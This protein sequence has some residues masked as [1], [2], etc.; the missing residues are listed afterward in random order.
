MKD[1]INIDILLVEDN[2]A[3]IFL[4]KKMLNASALHINSVYTTD[5]VMEAREVL[6]T[7]H[8]HVALLDLSL[9]DSFGIDTYLEI[10]S[11]VKEIPVIILTGLN[12]ANTALEALKEGAQDY[13]IKGEFNGDLLYRAIQYSLE[14]KK[15]E[16]ALLISEEKYKQMFYQGFFPSWIYDPH[17]LQFLEVND[18]AIKKYGY[19]REE[20]LAMTLKDI[21][22]EEDVAELMNIVDKHEAKGTIKLWRHKKKNGNIMTVEVSFFPVNYLG[23]VAS[24]AQMHDVTEEVELQKKLNEQQKAEQKNIT[25]AVLKALESDRA[26]LGAELHDNIN[27]ILATSMLYL[28]HAKNNEVEKDQMIHKSLDVIAL[29]I[30]EIRK[31]SRKLVVS[32]ISEIGLEKSIRIMI[33]SIVLVKKKNISLHMEKFPEKK[34]DGNVKVA[35]YRIIQEQLTNILKHANASTVDIELKKEEKL[36]I[37][38]IADNGKG[39]DTT[40]QRKGVGI[41]NIISRVSIY[42]GEVNIS[43][44]PGRGCTLK[45]TLQLKN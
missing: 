26:H 42:D 20:F 9:P 11:Y 16:E 25:S 18:A 38:K 41:T 34:A 17:S 31:L 12:D 4:L 33:D 29:A 10:K 2:P 5:K 37:L 44:A 21:R 30:A 6:Q 14:R 7:L 27:Q 39:F 8:F 15:V 3:D 40:V 1:T 19:N 36:I 28:E 22:P 24:Q 32:D 35:I 13:L 43:S 23:K 45:V